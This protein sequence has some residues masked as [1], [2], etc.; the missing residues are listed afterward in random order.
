[1]TTSKAAQVLRTCPACSRRV[2]QQVAAGC[3]ICNGH[4]V[5]R[6]GRPAL[7]RY[8]VEVV[9]RAIEYALELQAQKSLEVTPFHLPRAVQDLRDLMGK[10][11]RAGVV[12]VLEPGQ[13]IANMT[14]GGSMSDMATHRAAAEL[15]AESSE[16]PYQ[17]GVAAVLAAPPVDIDVTNLPVTGF[18]NPFGAAGYIAGFTQILDPVKPLDAK[19]ADHRAMERLG[20]VLGEAATK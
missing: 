18:R 11:R 14:V 3:P 15:A 20:K 13:P 16:L 19:H 1:M 8:P 17:P 2:N 9:S 12:G 7:L 4:G 10:L 6:L 5:I